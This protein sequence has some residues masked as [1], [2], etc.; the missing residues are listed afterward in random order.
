MN[1]IV[2]NKNCLKIQNHFILYY[3][4]INNFLGNKLSNFVIIIAKIN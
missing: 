4:E 2:L 1:E 3:N